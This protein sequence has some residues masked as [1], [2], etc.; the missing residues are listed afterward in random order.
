MAKQCQEMDAL[1]LHSKL[2]VPSVEALMA[3]P[4]SMYIHF[5]ANDCG[6]KGPHYELIANWVHL[7]FL[8]AKSEAS[9]EHIPNWKQ[10]INGPIKEEY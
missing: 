1:L 4:L 2:K 3:C 7:L 10:A 8:K 6:Y 5:A 9:K